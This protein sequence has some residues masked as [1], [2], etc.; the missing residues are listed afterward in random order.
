LGMVRG[1]GILFRGRNNVG[2]QTCDRHREVVQRPKDM[3]SSNRV[4]VART[5]RPYLG[6]VV[7]RAGLSTSM[8]GAVIE[9]DIV[10]NKRQKNQRKI[11]VK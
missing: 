9:Y 11:K 4:V 7:E 3:A 6:P 1:L 8:R 2:V 10:A 5:V